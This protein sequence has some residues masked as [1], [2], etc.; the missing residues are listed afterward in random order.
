[1]LSDPFAKV[2]ERMREISPFHEKAS[3][4]MDLAEQAFFFD[5]GDEGYARVMFHPGK[6]KFRVEFTPK[7]LAM[8]ED[9]QAFVLMHEVEHV[10]RGHMTRPK[11]ATPRRWNVAGDACIN[12][13]LIDE[14]YTAMRLDAKLVGMIITHARIEVDED[15]DTIDDVYRQLPPDAE[16]DKMCPTGGITSDDLHE[17]AQEGSEE[18]SDMEEAVE[19]LIR[20]VTRSDGEG[21]IGI[22]TRF[23]DLFAPKH[24]KRLSYKSLMQEAFGRVK[25][26]PTPTFAK[27]NKR[28]WATHGL[29]APGTR[30]KQEPRIFIGCDTSGSVMGY[31][32]WFLQELNNCIEDLGVAVDLFFTE[33]FEKGWHHEVTSITK[34]IFDAAGVYD[35][36]GGGTEFR[37]VYPQLIEKDPK[38]DLVILLTDCYTDCP[39]A[40]LHSLMGRTVILNVGRDN[41]TWPHCE[42]YA[43]DLPDDEWKG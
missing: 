42:V 20:E 19:E 24:K 14:H 37:W 33:A 3:R 25:P 31:I 17:G 1:M 13:D 7:L 4:E 39:P 21:G 2:L 38:Y 18:A 43:T 40:P 10:L 30:M 35:A 26:L 23:Q 16:L 29:I 15:Y 6:Q 27:I 9:T 32:P 5:T 11:H 22:P 8:D 28:K 34:E 36:R 41:T 12:D